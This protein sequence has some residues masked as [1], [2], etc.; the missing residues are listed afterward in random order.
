MPEI[1]EVDI[2]AGWLNEY[3]QNLPAPA[4]LTGARHT[5]PK[6]AQQWQICAPYLLGKTLR[7]IGRK[8]KYLIW[9]WQPHSGLLLT[10][11]RMTGWWLWHD[12]PRS[13]S[14]MRGYKLERHARLTLDFQVANRSC[15][16]IFCDDRV[17]GE[18]A[19]FPVA[20]WQ[21]I[22]A[23]AQQAP[24]F[25]TTSYTVTEGSWPDVAAFLIQAQLRQ[26]LSP[27]RRVR[28]LLL[29]QTQRGAGA[30]LGNYMVAEILY[31]AAIHPDRYWGTLTVTELQQFYQI[32]QEFLHQIIV[33]K[34]DNDNNMVIYQRDLCPQQHPIT[35][36]IRGGR[37]SYY[38]EVCQP[39]NGS[40]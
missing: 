21:E 9:E 28:D 2:L 15:Q 25:I 38:C 1:A 36:A 34:A 14:V 24:D 27:R 3:L 11:L 37:S 26:Q 17:L 22:P 19:Y 4:V 13:I 12:N 35:R 10:H 8:G 18:L 33:N 6:L 39:R 40:Q 30:G 32:T 20:N 5:H 23:L 16:L 29:D 31:R 7:H